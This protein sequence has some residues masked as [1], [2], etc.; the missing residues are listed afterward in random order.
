MSKAKQQA[1]QDERNIELLEKVL[2]GK[3]TIAP[4]EAHMPNKKASQ[5]NRKGGAAPDDESE[6][7]MMGHYAR[8]LR[9]LLPGIVAKLS[10]IEDPRD[11]HKVTH[12]LPALILFGILMFLSQCTSR[13]SANRS[14]AHSNMLGMV[15]EFVPGAVAMPH[16]DTLARLLCDIDTDQ[17]DRHYEGMIKSFIAS[18]QFKEVQTGR[19]RVAVDGT[20]KFSRK[21]EWDERALSQNAGNEEKQRY[22]VYVLESSLIL[23]NG[24][25]LPLLTEILENKNDGQPGAGN[26]SVAAECLAPT[27]SDDKKSDKKADASEFSQKQDC[28][29]KA[30]HRLAERLAKLLGKG[31]VSLVLDG[32]YATGPVISRCEAYGW[33]YMIV[34]KNECLKTV[35][36]DFYGLRKIESANTTLIQYGQRFQEFH[37]SNELEYTYGKNHKRLSLNLVTCTEMWTEQRL[38]RGKKPKNMK[39]EYAWLSSTPITAANVFHLCTIV[40]RSRWRIENLFLT[41]KHQGYCYSHCF[42]YNWNAMKGFHYLMKFGLFLN[43]VLAFSEDLAPYVKIEGKRGFV[44]LVWKKITEGKWPAFEIN[45]SVLPKGSVSAVAKQKTKFPHFIN[46][47]AAA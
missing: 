16:T 19:Y 46:L 38:R 37:W 11:E 40:A 23:D 3:S 17:I 8:L 42:S 45:S 32:I 5:S 25:T 15:A 30:F 2:S 6:A 41:L 39:T 12:S 47:Q 22:Y 9:I 20:Q 28:E 1:K 43:V 10:Q 24:M 31:C 7:Q 13:R 21:Y 36:E 35:W 26:P 4:I 14:I 33:D 44:L 29:T 34:L 18:E 27:G